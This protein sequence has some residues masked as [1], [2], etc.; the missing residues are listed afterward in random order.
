M[1]GGFYCQ[2]DCFATIENCILRDNY[3]CESGGAVFCGAGAAPTFTACTFIDNQA[4]LRGGALWIINDSAP[5]F[6]GC[7][8]VGNSAPNGAGLAVQ[9]NSFVSVAHS[10]FAFNDYDAIYC[11]GSA[12]VQATCTNVYGHPAGDWSGCLAGQLGTAG[13]ISANPIFCDFHARDLRLASGSPCLPDNHPSCGLIG[14]WGQ[15]C[16]SSDVAGE[17]PG[18]AR[19]LLTVTNPFTLGSTAV[20]RVP[21]ADGAGAVALSVLDVHG[22]LVARLAGGWFAPGAHTATWDARDLSGRAVPEGVYFCRLELS[23]ALV[24][25]PLIVVR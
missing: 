15:G 24:T 3:S 12:A 9:L 22:R 20:F 23:G 10:I 7:T 21:A 19:D 8:F 6:D 14:A 2:G 1:G 11:T 13:N 16:M 17:S 18:I 4:G 5:S 25:R